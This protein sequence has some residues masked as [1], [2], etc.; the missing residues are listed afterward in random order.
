[1]KGFTSRLFRPGVRHYW[2]IAVVALF[3]IYL[4]CGYHYERW[5][6]SMVPLNSP[7]ARTGEGFIIRCDGLGYYAWLRSLVIDGDR[8]SVV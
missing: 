4:F 5:Y 2:A 6:K 3:Q 1:M 8:K 7:R